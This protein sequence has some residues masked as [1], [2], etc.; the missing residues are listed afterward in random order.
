MV[1]TGHTSLNSSLKKDTQSMVSFVDHLIHPLRERMVA[2]DLKNS[3]I[4]QP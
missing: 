4:V 2:H 1:R 3:F